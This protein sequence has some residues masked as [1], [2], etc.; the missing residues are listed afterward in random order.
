MSRMV[1]STQVVVF[2]GCAPNLI[3]NATPDW[4]DILV[5]K[6]NL[7]ESAPQPVNWHQCKI[8]LLF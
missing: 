2:F 6:S 1:N 8:N 5:C 7:F 3:M 4:S